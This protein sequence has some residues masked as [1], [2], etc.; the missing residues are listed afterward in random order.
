M[1]RRS[2]LAEREQSVN[3]GLK[4]ISQRIRIADQAAH[5]PPGH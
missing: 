3:E 5:D 1:M 2:L 4:Q